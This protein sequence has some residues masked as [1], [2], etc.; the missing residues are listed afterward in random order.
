MKQETTYWA[1]IYLS[2]DI[3][4]IKQVC[5]EYCK[6][7]GLCLTVNET[8]FIYTGGE[9]YGVEIGLLNYPRF[10]DTNGKILSKAMEIGGLCRDKCFQHSFLVMTP[11]DTFWHTNRE[12]Q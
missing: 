5:R 9:E 2:G 6:S 10:P 1:K 8:L 3:N 11:E 4:V 7:V 12:N